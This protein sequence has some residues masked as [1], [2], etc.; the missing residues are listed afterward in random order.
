MRIL[1]SGAT[2]LVGSALTRALQAAGGEILALRRKAHAPRAQK[3]NTEEIAWSQL[4]GDSE[5]GRLEGLDAVVHLAGENVAGGRWTAA[6]RAAIRD[7]RIDGT[8]DLSRA[9]ARCAQPPPVLV[10]A[11]AVGYYGDGGE[12]WLDESSPPGSD[13]LARVAVAWE[14]AA[15]AARAAGIRVVHLRFGIVLA[16]SGGALARMLPLFRLGLG[17]RLGHGRQYMSWLSLTEAVSIIRFAISQAH[18]RGA[19]NAVSPQPVTNAEFTR[20]LAR[21]LRRPALLPVPAWA[22]RAALGEMADALLLAGTRVRPLHLQEA[23]YTFLHPELE[24]AL[25]ALLGE[26]S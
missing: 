26:T 3:V 25:R 5:T 6:R 8:G 21:V 2:G 1:I 11:S 24:P 7:S 22:A 14:D 19:V 18:L 20:T 10:S 13:F 16:G 17:G 12:A 15:G 9:L 23:G 4:T